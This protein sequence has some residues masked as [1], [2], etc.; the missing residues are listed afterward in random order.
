MAQVT[1]PVAVGTSLSRRHMEHRLPVSTCTHTHGWG[2][3]SWELPQHPAVGRIL[4][5]TRKML[6]VQ[7]TISCKIQPLFSLG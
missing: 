2:K 5:I 6:M 3:H 1:L 7:G 4:E